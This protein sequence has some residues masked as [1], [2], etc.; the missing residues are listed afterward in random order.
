MAI[1]SLRDIGSREHVVQFYQDDADL[2]D[3]VADYVRDAVRDGGVAIVIAAPHHRLAF[4]ER[5]TGSGVDMAAASASGAYLE[6]DAEDTLRRFMAGDTPDPA[7]FDTV[8]GRVIRAA[9]EGGRQVRAY[10]EMVALLWDAGLV[11][12]AIELEAM[13]NDLGRAE[14]FSLFCGY[15][16]D[17]VTDPAQSHA[18]AEVCGQ[19]ASVLDSPSPVQARTFSASL[20]SVTDA[21][22]FVTR[23]LRE[24]EVADPSADAALSVTEFAANAVLH[25]RSAFTVTLLT[26][27]DTVRITVRDSAP[28]PP[29]TS[30]L[31]V[32][33][34]HGLGAVAAMARRWGV[35]PLGAS[36]KLVWCELAR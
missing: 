25:G 8:V 32:R 10:G 15:P 5:L 29:G 3:K 24:W 16:L 26:T 34:L 2:A 11:T 4:R 27:E 23:T 9:A 35:E 14:A 21:R 1:G 7:S 6:F 36:G 28:F 19:H 20:D 22:H 17:S 13:W 12:A 33:P 30:S 31:P 18:L